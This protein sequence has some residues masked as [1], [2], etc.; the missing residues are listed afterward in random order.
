[1]V[2]STS[3]VDSQLSEL[4]AYLNAWIFGAGQKGSDNRGSSYNGGLQFVHSGLTA[5]EPSLPCIT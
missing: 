3:N 4:F 1:M 5:L 2:N